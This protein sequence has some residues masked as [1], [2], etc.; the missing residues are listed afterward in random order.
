[1]IS[2]FSYPLSTDQFA[3]IR[4]RN[5][6]YVDK[7]GLMYNLV[8]QY[9]YVLLSRPRRF[10]K[11]LLCNTLHAYFEGRRELFEGLQVAGMETEWTQYPVLHFIMS[12]LKDLPM[13]K[14]QGTLEGFL[15]HYEKIYGRDDDD[16]TPGNRFRGLIRHAYQKTGRQVVV[17]MD[18]YDAPV[19]SLLYEK[20]KLA[21]MRQ[22]MREFYQVLKDEGQYLR[23]VFLTGV[24]KF[25]AIS[26]FSA[27]NNLKDISMLDEYSGLCGIT[28]TELDTVLR[29]HVEEFAER[30]G[31][32]TD[33]AYRALKRR[34]DGYHFSK[35]SEDV[36]APFSLLNC[37]SDGELNDYWFGTS[38][39]SALL[40]HLQHFPVKDIIGLDGIQL[41]GKQ[42]NIPYE[43][44]TSPVPMLYQSGY[45]SIKS[46]DPRKNHYTL[47]FP[48]TEVRSSMLEC[49]M[50]V[51]L[52]RTPTD[53]DSL[54]GSLIDAVIDGNLGQGIAALRSYIAGIPY[55]VITKE[56]WDEQAGRERFYQMLFYIVF[57]ILNARV[58]AEVKSI[59]GRADVVVQTDTDVF[60]IEFKV[61]R[62]VEDALAQIE[63]KDYAVAWQADG[64]RVTKCGVTVTSA[65]R[66]IT[67]WRITDAD[68]NVLEDTAF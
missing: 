55:D 56:E 14:A 67:H 44:A 3:K 15:R 46:Y 54:I 33:E 35:H 4:M 5:Q 34:Y 59:L 23:F 31:K 45:L 7:T 36:Y 61:D 57:S 11:S 22:M 8:Q 21:Q 53:S 49:L 41:H 6:V 19:V 65:K 9:D 28:Q 39:S 20:E 40:E 10:G 63:A 24:T 26:I 2:K 60:V 17:I 12:G 27:L 29:P 64:R 42:F 51:I 37:L 52:H 13:E 25:S 62:P 58:D 68:G 66:N 30:M 50:P 48:N 1:M 18:E 16:V 38:T 43:D 32:T 47:H